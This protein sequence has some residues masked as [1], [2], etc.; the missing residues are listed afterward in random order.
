TPPGSSTDNAET[1]EDS[2]MSAKDRSVFD[3]I[4]E[5]LEDSIQFTRG[6]LTLRTTKVPTRPPAVAAKQIVALRRKLRM[7]QGVFARVLNVSVKTVQGWEQGER[8]PSQAALRLLQVM[9]AQPEAVCG[10]AG[11]RG[12]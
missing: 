7:S 4:K 3:L 8:K 11:L 5:G 12:Q 6:E 10:A 9:Q 2:R 1:K